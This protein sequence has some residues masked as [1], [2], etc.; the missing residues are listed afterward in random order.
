MGVPV[1]NH[2]GCRK[3]NILFLC[4]TDNM[5]S[6]VA[7]SGISVSGERGIGTEDWRRVNN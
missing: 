1:T 3:E 4:D 6:G 7:T 2:R 5:G